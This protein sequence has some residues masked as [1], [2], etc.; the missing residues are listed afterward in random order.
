[1]YLFLRNFSDVSNSTLTIPKTMQLLTGS[2]KAT[3]KMVIDINNEFLFMISP[4]E[5]Y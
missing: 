3:L 5:N 2:H 1:M 4:E